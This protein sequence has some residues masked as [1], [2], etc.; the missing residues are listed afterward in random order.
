[1]AA[2]SPDFWELRGEGIRV[3][4]ALSRDVWTDYNLHDPG[5]MMLEAYCYALSE[6]EYRADA[7]MADQLAGPDGFI[8]YAALKLAHPSKA[9]AAR[10]VTLAQ[11]SKA[12]SAVSPAVRRARVSLHDAAHGHGLYDISVVAER[13]RED[14]A[15]L[16]VQR[17][18]LG[19]RNLCEDFHSITTS[20]PVPCRLN[21][22][23]EV[24]RRIMP[25]YLAALIYFEC[26]RALID[27]SAAAQASHVTRNEAFL[28]PELLSGAP[29]TDGAVRT[30]AELFEILM[31]I[32]DVGG[33]T[34]LDITRSDTGASIFGAD[35]TLEPG[36]HYDLLELA[37]TTDGVSSQIVLSA[38]GQRI[39]FEVENMRRELERLDHASDL[40]APL[41]ADQRDWDVVRQGRP[42]D[43]THKPIGFDLPEAFLTGPS[44]PPPS[45][46]RERLAK[47]NQLRGY[48]ALSDMQLNNA[49]A[50]QAGLG[51]LFG[52][53]IATEITYPERASAPLAGHDLDD[54][55]DRKSRLL[56]YLLSLYGE[57][58]SQSSLRYFFDEPDLAGR[59]RRILR[60]K[61]R[62]LDAVSE[63]SRDRAA[64]S[65]Y[66]AQRD[67]APIGMARKLSILLDLPDF[68][69]AVMEK[70][71][72]QVGLRL[73]DGPRPGSSSG[74][75]YYDPQ[76]IPVEDLGQLGARPAELIERT[77]FLQGGEVSSD[78]LRFLVALGNY[79]LLEG[80]AGQWRL[81]VRVSNWDDRHA[82][83]GTF[84]SKQE[85]R[86]RANHLAAFFGALMQ[87]AER[88]HHQRFHIVE[89]I[90]LR[91]GCDDWAPL[92]L[93]VVFCD[94]AGKRRDPRFHA[95]AQE[96]AQRVAPAHI[97]VACLWLDPATFGEFER[98]F[99]HW[100]VQMARHC[101][102]PHKAPHEALRDASAALRAFL[103]AHQGAS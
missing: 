51:H 77:E 100:R 52:A 60:G 71:L 95:L 17:A 29:D 76:M 46:G 16:A 92:S 75:L 14:E 93:V 101:V 47:V 102:G 19:L 2:P 27:K 73:V 66:S 70:G 54:W 96:T 26:K 58:F 49:N 82:V 37:G 1:M 89:D 74:W 24:N 85:A 88:G 86:L 4:Q 18:Y 8:D 63:I 41:R 11:I 97:A 87:A 64:G 67:A 12:L 33:I 7:D 43:W 15:T 68:D 25:G 57:A 80:Q 99:D 45:I 5:V 38:G 44:D 20:R 21:V 39:E 91:H 3:A 55:F 13:G 34:A 98:L 40:V 84:D 32:G 22:S 36:A 53:D 103:V 23:V 61:L 6:L 56:D 72:A 79:R 94:V 42:L 48:L 9:L 65:D 81:S 50:E 62:L 31:G 69:P 28:N 59:H 10:P 78:Q 35:V 83:C 30:R 90:L